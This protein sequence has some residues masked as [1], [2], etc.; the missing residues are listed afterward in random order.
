MANRDISSPNRDGIIGRI[1]ALV[2]SRF[3]QAN[4][5]V[6]RRNFARMLELFDEQYGTV[7]M[8]NDN[9]PRWHLH[10]WE[11]TGPGMIDGM[12]RGIALTC[13]DEEQE[14]QADDPDELGERPEEDDSDPPEPENEDELVATATATKTNK[15]VKKTKKT[16]KKKESGEAPP[17]EDLDSSDPLDEDDDLQEPDQS[18]DDDLEPED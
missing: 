12:V 6:R 7:E 13:L 8:E 16:V 15:K 11:R 14:R 18:A 1:R 3:A 17:A 2:I 10:W 5:P 9:P 4:V